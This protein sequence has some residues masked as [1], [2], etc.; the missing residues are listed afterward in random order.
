MTPKISIIGAG[1]ARFSLTLIRDLCLTPN[2]AGCT[3]SL[4]DVDSA[5]LA[6][7]QKICQRY[8]DDGLFLH[9]FQICAD[10]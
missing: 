8:A 5:R 9:G 4:M 2:L 10:R 3:V 1:S 6:A 7:A